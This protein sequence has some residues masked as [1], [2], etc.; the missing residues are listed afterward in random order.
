MADDVEI[1]KIFDKK[2][3]EDARQEIIDDSVPE[4]EYLSAE[5]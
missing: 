5:E 4:D 1:K 3:N 2:E